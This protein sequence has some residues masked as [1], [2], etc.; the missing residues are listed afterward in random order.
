MRENVIRG[1]QQ[2]LS[3]SLHDCTDCTW[4]SPDPRRLEPCSVHW[5]HI[6]AVECA[7]SCSCDGYFQADYLGQHRDSNVNPYG[8]HFHLTH[9][10]WLTY[11]AT[12]V[13]MSIKL[14]F[15]HP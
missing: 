7:F 1:F 3:L 9:T 5:I 14:K 6:S 11:F 2:P 4:S 13:H 15:K 10:F 12:G 8:H